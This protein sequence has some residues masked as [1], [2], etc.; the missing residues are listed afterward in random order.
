MVRLHGELIDIGEVVL[1]FRGLVIIRDET[2]ELLEGV[3]S[4]A[5]VLLAGFVLGAI[6]MFPILG[7]L[8]GVEPVVGGQPSVTPAVAADDLTVTPV[9]EG[10]V[11]LDPDEGP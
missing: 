1:P 2:V 6:T 7:G 3:V 11:T 4:T 9:T 5:A 8:F 10:T